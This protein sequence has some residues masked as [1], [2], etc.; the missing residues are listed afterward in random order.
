MNNVRADH[1]SPSVIMCVTI[2]SRSGVVYPTSTP[3]QGLALKVLFETEVTKCRPSTHTDPPNWPKYFPTCGSDVRQSPVALVTADALGTFPRLTLGFKNYDVVPKSM[4]LLNNGHTGAYD[5]L[6]LS[7]SCVP[8]ISPF[9]VPLS[10]VIINLR[11]LILQL[12][13][14]NS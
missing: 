9:L 5:P 2:S 12:L 4:I 7:S 6:L 1:S 10:C 13:K 8:Y 11:C 3:L 14:V